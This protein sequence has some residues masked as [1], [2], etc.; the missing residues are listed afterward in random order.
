[1][2]FFLEA[3][4]ENIIG[5]GFCR[6]LPSGDFLI[7]AEVSNYTSRPGIELVLVSADGD[8]YP[9]SSQDKIVCKWQDKTSAEWRIEADR[10]MAF[11][12]MYKHLSTGATMHLLQ[13]NITCLMSRP[14]CFF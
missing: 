5:N 7:Y 1:M 2:L 9:A 10:N 4:L 14:K 11:S 6:E 13:H 3:H 8:S 12:L